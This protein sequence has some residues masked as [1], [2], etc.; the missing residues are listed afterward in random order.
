MTTEQLDAYDGA[1]EVTSGP[2]GIICRENRNHRKKQSIVLDRTAADPGAPLLEV[3][4]GHGLHAPRYAEEFQYTGI[5]LSP[6]LVRETRRR[7]TAVD[8]DASVEEMDATSLEYTDDAFDAVVGTA[9]LHH[10]SDQETALREWARVTRPGGS[11]T[12]MEPNYLFPLAFATTHQLSEEK[13]KRG[14]APWRLRETLARV[15]GV[16][17]TVEPRLYTPP[18]PAA[19][20]GLYDGVDS[21]AR[22]VPALRWGSMMLLIHGDVQ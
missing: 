10:L 6:S 22:R 9:I 14:M 11:V 15:D 17:W 5:D 21:L 1:D 12:L 16:E 4:C 13:H 8:P 3:G 7:V 2:F 20:A 18:W 19:A